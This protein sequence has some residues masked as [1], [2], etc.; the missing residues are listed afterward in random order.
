M[1]EHR[2]VIVIAD[3]SG[4]G[5][6]AALFMALSRIVVSVSAPRYPSPSDV[7][8]AA[9]AIIA[10]NSRSGMF[11]TLF[12]GILDNTR[13]TLTYT[14]AGHNPPL[15]FR[16]GSGTVEE[17]PAT[18]IALGAMEDFRY[19]QDSAALA[20]GDLIVLYTDGITEA[21]NG[22]EEM[23][24]TDRLLLAVRENSTRSSREIV[25]KVIGSVITFCGNQPQFDDITL[26]V[27]KVR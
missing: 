27:I 26:M 19:G 15:V 11:V 8:S 9:N 4:K 24:G 17:L 13:L 25:D 18:G 7:I 14:N 2:T 20:A 21:M 5:I 3:V 1:P 22:R 10:T 23:F 12:Y 16:A 6:P